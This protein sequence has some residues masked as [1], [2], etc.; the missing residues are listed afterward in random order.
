MDTHIDYLRLATW[1]ISAYVQMMPFL[2]ELWPKD[3]KRG[4]W[5]QYTGWRKEGLFIGRGEQGRKAHTILNISGAL[6]QTW[7]V[8]LLSLDGWYCTR[9]DLQRTIVSTLAEDEK[10]SQVRDD[11]TTGK[12]TLIESEENDTLYLGSRT[13]D[14]FTRL[15][16]KVLEGTFLR[17]EFELKGFRARSCWEALCA[18]EEADKIFV[19]YLERSALPERVKSDYAREGDIATDLAMRLEIE[20]DA[21]KALKWI[22]SLDKSMMKNMASHDIG[23]Q[24]K[25]IVRAWAKYAE[26][27][28]S[29]YIPF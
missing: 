21:Q 26:H 9:I 8:S 25:I 2:M 10:L 27:L 24:V 13:S 7:H 5:L 29:A 11:C 1:D 14:L 3:W 23:E 6:S 15:Y 16:E 20:K 18:G 12:T 17:L 4:K 28:D 22:I 19:F